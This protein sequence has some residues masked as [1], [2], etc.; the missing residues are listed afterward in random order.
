[1]DNQ[2]HTSAIKKT[3]Y[4]YYIAKKIANLIYKGLDRIEVY[5]HSVI[6]VNEAVQSLELIK[7]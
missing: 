1:M 7:N 6:T 5:N 3:P 2:K 4:K